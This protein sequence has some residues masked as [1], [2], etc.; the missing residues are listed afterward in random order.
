MALRFGAEGMHFCICASN[1]INWT[2]NPWG[3]KLTAYLGPVGR[4]PRDGEMQAADMAWPP[5]SAP[6]PSREFRLVIPAGGVSWYFDG[7]PGLERRPSPLSAPLPPH[8]LPVLDQLLHA[9][10]DNAASRTLEMSPRTF[11]RRVAEILEHLGVQTRFQGGVS[12]ALSGWVSRTPG[13]G[14]VCEDG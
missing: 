4:W 2:P 11:S 14:A 1:A 9:S 6:A 13:T 3:L 8:L 10:T 12:V 5:S 7:Q